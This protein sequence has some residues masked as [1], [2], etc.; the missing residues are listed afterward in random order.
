MKTPQGAVALLPALG[1]RR[2]IG[3]GGVRAA[4]GLAFEDRTAGPCTVSEGERA[5]N[6]MATGAVGS[7]DLI[8]REVDALADQGGFGFS[9]GAGY[10]EDEQHEE[11][12]DGRSIAHA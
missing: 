8:A 11:T 5:Y 7:V 10:N 4:L 6:L 9:L 1:G 2:E 3:V 12:H